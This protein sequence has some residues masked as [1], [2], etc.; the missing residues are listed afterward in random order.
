MRG[1]VVALL[2][3]GCAGGDGVAPARGPSP[4]AVVPASPT[5]AARAVLERELAAYQALADRACGCPTGTCVAAVDADL[6]QVNATATLDEP[7]T[8]T[9]A[10]P[11]DL[12]AYRNYL[13]AQLDAC[14]SDLDHRLTGWQS[15]VV[16]TARALRDVACA[17]PDAGCAAQADAAMARMHAELGYLGLDRSHGAELGAAR[18]ATRRCITEIEVDQAL[19]EL[20]EI[21]DA[22]CACDEV[23][24]ALAVLGRIN[25]WA[26]A[27]A[28]TRFAEVGRQQEVDAVAAELR[29]CTGAPPAPAPAP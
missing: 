24:C 13:R 11:S 3:A 2:V 7:L 20:S 19:R 15:Y 8:G 27:Y 6:D 9:T 1:V 12:G 26:D 23:G 28:H 22:E 4:A 29:A 14:M 10:W 17:C 16:R 18:R 5:G 25:T 21:R